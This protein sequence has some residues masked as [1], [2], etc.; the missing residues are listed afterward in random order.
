MDSRTA[1]STPQ[2]QPPAKHPPQPP[3][4]P[5][6]PPPSSESVRAVAGSVSGHGSGNNNPPRP[7]STE[8]YALGRFADSAPDDGSVNERLAFLSIPG[9][10][11][12]E[13]GGNGEMADRKRDGKR[14]AKRALRDFNAKYC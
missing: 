14:K 4:P 12:G 13:R 2:P 1:T 7:P 10:T 9:Y 3:P 5:P 6:P 11:M 8:S